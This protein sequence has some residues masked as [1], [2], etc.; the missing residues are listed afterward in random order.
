M[1]DEPSLIIDSITGEI[2]SLS[3]VKGHR[4]RCRLD[5]ADDV[6][7]ELAK[8][9]RETRS[10]LIEPQ[11]STKMGWLLGE[12]RKAIETTTIEARLSALEQEN[13]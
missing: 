11:D 6:R 3:P 13:G 1:S 2:E 5:T 10:G 12:V 9:Y 8:L 4:Y 7:R